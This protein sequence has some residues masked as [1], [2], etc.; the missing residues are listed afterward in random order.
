MRRNF[1]KIGNRKYFNAHYP[2]AKKYEFFSMLGQLFISLPS[3]SVIFALI[4]YGNIAY[5]ISY[6]A[7]LSAFIGFVGAVILEAVLKVSTVDFCRIVRRKEKGW[8][9]IIIAFSIMIVFYG[10]CG[11][12]SWQGF[13]YA[14]ESMIPETKLRDVEKI[15]S[16]HGAGIIELQKMHESDVATIKESYAKKIKASKSKTRALVA[17]QDANILAWRKKETKWTKFTSRIN[18][19]KNNKAKIQATGKSDIAKLQVKQ[20][21]EISTLLKDKNLIILNRENEKLNQVGI[22]ASLN[23]SSIEKRNDTVKASGTIGGVLATCLLAFVF[24]STNKMEDVKIKS[25]VQYDIELRD[26]EL[27]DNFISEAYHIFRESMSLKA[28]GKLYEK[29]NRNKKA[30]E[31]ISDEERYYSSTFN[32]Y[33]SSGQ[34]VKKIKPITANFSTD[35]SDKNVFATME[36]FEKNNTPKTDS[37]NTQ[38][39]TPEI[40][41]KKEEN[42]T[43]LSEEENNSITLRDTSSYKKNNTQIT[44]DDN[45]QITPSELQADNTRNITLKKTENNTLDIAAIKRLL[46]EKGKSASMFTVM[47]Q[48]RTSGKL[49][50]ITLKKIKQNISTYKNKIKDSEIRHEKLDNELSL[51][52]LNDRKA[53]LTYWEGKREELYNKIVENLES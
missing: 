6:G 14:S 18:I 52:T 53:V 21:D 50:P 49:E 26:R 25:D 31:K 42:N 35:Q 34:D 45:R 43:L 51:K 11:T 4:F 12:A 17:V 40:T 46:S 27:D 24:Y 38:D 3:E 33:E 13:Q 47:H 19:H 15:K 5:L 48:N 22:A 7:Y 20:G 37:D 1:K 32:E 36:Y 23:K 9:E 10:V 44:P 2:I 16:D 28:R 39:N 29:A 41:G 8:G 30:A